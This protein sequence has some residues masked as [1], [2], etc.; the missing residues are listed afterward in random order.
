VLVAVAIEYLFEQHEK[1]HK[2][3]VYGF[4]KINLNENNKYMND[5]F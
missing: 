1:I 2:K 4:F 3:E 5:N